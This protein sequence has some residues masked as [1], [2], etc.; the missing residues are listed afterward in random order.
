[1]R[2]QYILRISTINELYIMDAESSMLSVRLNNCE[3]QEHYPNEKAGKHPIEI[4]WADPNKVRKNR[5][6]GVRLSFLTI[7]L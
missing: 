5:A 2:R 1:M 6:F 7:R 3:A 4:S